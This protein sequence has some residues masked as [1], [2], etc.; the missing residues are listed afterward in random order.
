MTNK[1]GRSHVRDKTTPVISLVSFKGY[2]HVRWRSGNSK[3]SLLQSTLPRSS[4]LSV[5][6]MLSSLLNSSV[7]LP[8]H[9]AGHKFS[10]RE[11]S[12]RHTLAFSKHICLRLTP[13]HFSFSPGTM[14]C[15]GG[16]A[17]VYFLSISLLN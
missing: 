7:C 2:L 4:L 5:P 8:S 16:W 14:G 11:A 3:E 17:G 12:E 1:P 13:L 15:G 10:S 6:W 9:P